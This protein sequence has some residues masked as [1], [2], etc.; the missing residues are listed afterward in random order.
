[1]HQIQS[2]ERDDKHL[3]DMNHELI[4]SK[5]ENRR[6][7]AEIKFT[8]QLRTESL[9]RLRML[10]AERERRVANCEDISEGLVKKL[11][12]MKE[13]ERE[14]NVSKLKIDDIQRQLPALERQ[15]NVENHSIHEI[16]LIIE[17]LV[18]ERDE[19]MNKLQ[20][21]NLTYDQ[22]VAEISRERAQLESHNKRHTQL[23]T[24]KVIFQALEA[25]VLARK[26]A[27]LNEFFNYCKFDEKCHKTLKTFAGVLH[28]CGQYQMKAALKKWFQTALEPVSVIK[29][30]R[31]LIRR[32][33]LRQNAIQ[34]L[35]IKTGKAFSAAERQQHRQEACKALFAI[36]SLDVWKECC[37]YFTIWRDKMRLLKTREERLSHLI[38][39]QT[40][41][42]KR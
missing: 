33:R 6:V 30:A 12:V 37:R 17:R 26:Q 36:K 39:R 28:R 10:Q 3:H 24:S 20:H 42:R 40:S 38:S 41:N 4:H 7:Q 9:N 29:Q 8:D 13:L 15:N 19:L 14:I 23:L 18:R 27:S 2:E 16:H 5:E 32:Y 34:D 35:N 22:T 11:S 21:L 25:M 1:M 31:D